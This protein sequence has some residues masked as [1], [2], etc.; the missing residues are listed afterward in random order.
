MGFE[1][2]EPVQMPRITIKAPGANTLIFRILQRALTHIDVWLTDIYNA[3]LDLGHCPGQFR[4]ANTVVLKKP[5][6]DDYTQPKSYRPIA[7]LGTLGK[8][9]KRSSPRESATRWR[10]TTCSQWSTPGA[11]SSRLPRTPCIW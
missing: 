5:D 2:P 8:A 4:H 10:Y 11:G 1:Y 3:C 6:K 7:L 9:W